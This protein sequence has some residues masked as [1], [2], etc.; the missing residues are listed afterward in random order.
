MLHIPSASIYFFLSSIM[1]FGNKYLINEWGFNYPVALIS[2]QSILTLVSLYLI[3]KYTS[4]I[5]IELFSIA[6]SDKLYYQFLT[7]LFYSLHSI[8]ALT[9]LSGLNIPIYATFKR[10]GPLVNLILSYIMFQK[11]SADKEATD[12]QKKINL[13]I[14]FM[15]IG[16]ITAG[17]GHLKFD[18]HSY[19]YCGLS[20][21]F[22]ALYLSFIQKCGETEKNSMQTFYYSNILSIPML[23]VGFLFTNEIGDLQV[24]HTKYDVTGFGFLTAFGAVLVCGS[25]LCFT[26]FWCTSENTAL[27][28]SVI[29]VLKSFIQ[30][31]VGFF[32]FNAS[33]EIG[34]VGFI[35]IFINLTFGVFYT[36][37]KYIEKVT[38]KKQNSS[39]N[40]NTV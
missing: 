27:T 4:F 29:G 3:S 39:N 13:S 11:K 20:V 26:Q 8:T 40:L 23:L 36:Y 15:T 37:L 14:F 10:C 5:K 9:A 22:Q 32:L 35:G 34:L 24:Y 31:T 1:V 38:I 7:A 25:C 12:I 2:I 28:T 30:T 33:K 6:N 19:F 17:F 16:A 18:P 21:I